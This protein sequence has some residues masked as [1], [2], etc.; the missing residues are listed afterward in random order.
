MDALDM[1]IAQLPVAG[2]DGDR[3][4]PS[5]PDSLDNDHS[6]FEEYACDRS[7][8]PWIIFRAAHRANHIAALPARARA[9]LAALART[10]D[11][12]RPF[13]AIFARRELLT[14]RALQSMRTFYRSLDDLETD[15]FI[16]RPPQKRHGDAGLF[17]RAYLHL[18][19]KAAS[20]L[21][22]VNEPSSESLT[23][24]SCPVPETAL[25]EA[26]CFFT[27]PSATMADG[28][29][30]KDLYPTNQKRQPARLP[31]DLQRLL[32]LG[33]HEFLIFRLMREAK[34]NLKRLSDVV[35]ATWIHLQKATRPINYLRALLRS[36]VDFG[37]QIRTKHAAQA[38]ADTA[39]VRA[40]Q[41]DAIVVQHAG[42]LFFD[43]SNGRRFEVS[44]DAAQIAVHD[45]RE[46]T[47]RI[48]VGNWSAEF[49]D[50]LESGR[51][52]PAT[53]Q[54]ESE[55][56][57]KGGGRTASVATSLIRNDMKLTKPVRTEEIDQRL[58]DMKRFLRLACAG[59]PV[60]RRTPGPRN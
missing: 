37:H 14:G 44:E 11:A 20:L 41:I 59:E 30:Y 31:A 51:I 6:V 24:G 48:R 47:P 27:P 58:T 45:Y 52:A 29:I 40:A 15:G 50:A 60:F 43:T 42:Q 28:A 12:N 36:P 26:P 5:N 46:P 57:L 39:R 22:L 35:E 8:L 23:A 7:N 19:D 38:E 17:G 53:P 34:L 3:L 16:V 25:A 56:A 9:L 4:R 21:G 54:K 1:L 32:S 33:F 2:E 49:V 18:T 10:V 13:A 55:F